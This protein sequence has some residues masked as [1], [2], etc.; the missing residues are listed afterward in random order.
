M[1]CDSPEFTHLVRPVDIDA[2]AFACDWARSA[3]RSTLGFLCVCDIFFASFLSLS[4]LANDQSSTT[5][6]TH[7][8]TDRQS[9]VNELSPCQRNSGLID[10]RFWENQ[11]SNGQIFPLFVLFSFNHYGNPFGDPTGVT[12]IERGISNGIEGRVAGDG[13]INRCQ[14]DKEVRRGKGE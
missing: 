13:K 8:H 6:R 10:F 5:G 3:Q 12:S 11:K 4:S 7:T 9:T 2:R 1:Q 14:S